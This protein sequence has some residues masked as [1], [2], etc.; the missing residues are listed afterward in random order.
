MATE[1]TVPMDDK[2]AWAAAMASEPVQEAPQEQPAPAPQADEGRPRDEHGRF[3][4]QAEPDAAP[5]QQ[6]P[7]EQKPVDDAK[8]EDVANVPSWR[9]RE[10]NEARTAAERRAQE[11]AEEVRQSR[12][13]LHTLQQ[14]L[15]EL[16]KPKQEPIDFFADPNAA[17]KQSLDP[18]ETRFQTLSSQ[19]TLRASRAENVAIH[20]KDTVAEMEK[21]V[22][23]AMMDGHPE[24][25]ALGQ[26]MRQSDDP[27]GVAMQWYQRDKLL[28]ETGG[29]LSSYRTRIIEEALKDPAT[30]AKAVE[31]ARGQASQAPPGTRPNVQLPPSLNK[32]TGSGV[33]NAVADDDASD[34]ATFRYAMA[35]GRR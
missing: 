20:G 28:K 24:M 12:M 9:L 27:V 11:A 34:A 4:K 6:Q 13:Q 19:L 25:L 32:A 16:E 26:H 21:A 23:A 14:R 35:P 2:D 17:I 15:T 33:S 7:V 3:V 10:V 30:L 1:T 31:L 29:D 22:Q 5:I 18:I 8:P